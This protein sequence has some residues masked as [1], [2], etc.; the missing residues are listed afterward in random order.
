MIGERH[1]TYEY[2]TID[3]AR[4]AWERAERRVR[5][6][7]IYSY[8]TP[9]REKFYVTAMG[10]EADKPELLKATQILKRGSLRQAPTP[11]FALDFMRSRRTQTYAELAI[12][13]DDDV[14]HKRRFG[15]GGAIGTP[16]G[17]IHIRPRHG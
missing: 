7:T 13:N 10:E 4:A 15:T 3:L 11:S 16:D 1:V 6:C 14:R 17:G 8:T 2:A 9:Q 5:S 12:T